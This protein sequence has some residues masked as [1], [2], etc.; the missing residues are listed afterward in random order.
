VLQQ[1]AQQQG[2]RRARLDGLKAATA[3]QVVAQLREQQQQV[4]QA[5]AWVPTPPGGPPQSM[6][7]ETL[8]WHSSC[9]HSLHTPSCVVSNTIE[10][11]APFVSD[12]CCSLVPLTRHRVCVSRPLQQLCQGICVK[13]THT[14]THGLTVA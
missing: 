2:R 12:D 7:G 11:K 14:H 13:A 6:Q 5:A 9:R 1:Q 8:L 3:P 4:L 10:I